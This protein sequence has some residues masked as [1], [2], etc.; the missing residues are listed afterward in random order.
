MTY[1]SKPAREQ[2]FIQPRWPRDFR[3]PAMAMD[4]ASALPDKDLE[5]I[6]AWARENLSEDERAALAQALGGG[7]S[8][9]SD[10]VLNSA[11]AA[12]E[13]RS[14]TGGKG[15]GQP[16]RDGENTT[17]R[18]PPQKSPR[19]DG[20]RVGITPENFKAFLT[21]FCSTRGLDNS[22]LMQLDRLIDEALGKA[23]A[24]KR[25]G[26]HNRLVGGITASCA[27]PACQH[28]D[29]A[30]A[31]DSLARVNCGVRPTPAPARASASAFAKRY[32]NIV[33]SRSIR[34]A[35]PFPFAPATSIQR[36]RPAS[37]RASGRHEVRLG[38]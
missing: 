33:T 3:S 17:R 9:A 19:A 30:I 14:L 16:S 12:K 36:R 5:R 35:R 32:P 4:A 25:A 13:N 27:R 6:V 24:T 10:V 1:I 21:R 26:A 18:A 20:Q 34:W 28:H 11:S 29:A 38:G 8:S 15:P 31:A 23:D 2:L 7:A 37:R 22:E